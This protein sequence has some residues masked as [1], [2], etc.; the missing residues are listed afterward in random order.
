MTKKK[1]DDYAAKPVTEDDVVASIELEPDP[2]VVVATGEE[3][4]PTAT[5]SHKQTMN[6][7]FEKSRK[8][9]DLVRRNEG[10][11][12]VQQVEAL[13]AWAGQENPEGEA[14]PE[15][16]TNKPDRFSEDRGGES[17]EHYT[18]RLIAEQEAADAAGEGEGDPA[19]KEKLKTSPD[20]LQEGDPD[21]MVEVVILGRNLEV[22][23]QDIDDAG[24]IQAYQKGRSATIRLQRAATLETKA[25]STLDEIENRQVVAQPDADLSTDGLSDADIDSRYDGMM[26]VVAEG[27][28]EEIKE[29]IG[30]SLRPQ[31]V[32]QPIA[33]NPTVSQEV[34]VVKTE[35]QEELDAQFAADR[36]EANDMMVEEFHDIMEDPELL[37]LAQQRF[38][39]IK[40][41]PL[42]EGRSQKE[43]ARESATFVRSLGKRINGT[44]SK[45]NPAEVERKT[46]VERKRAMPTQTRADRRSPDQ[47]PKQKTVPSRKEHFQRLRNA[48]GHDLAR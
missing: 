9:R 18:A 23:Q 33:D 41:N 12:S 25:Q 13:Y 11:V 1:L 40:T 8:N 3:D 19:G 4:A 32:T 24:G 47:A 43:M 37:G 10:D 27:T 5:G 17:E 29:W 16:D 46:R 22:P 35:T 45:P 39:V 36:V 7:L 20:S 48:A 34:A 38:N 30:E 15:I 21:A 42:N 2:D 26:G 28:P 6:H 31:V 44:Y 14:P